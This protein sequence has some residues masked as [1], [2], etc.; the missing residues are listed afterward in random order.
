[1]ASYGVFLAAC[2]FEYH[3][4]KG[5]IGFAPRLTPENFKA[6][7]TSADGWGTFRQ[8]ISDKNHEAEIELRLGTLHVRTL[9]LATAA[10]PRIVTVTVAGD[11]AANEH[12]MENGRL[13]ITLT[14]PAR[15]E[16]GE[17]INIAIS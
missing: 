16:A 11:K 1:M 3:G 17:K 12:R 8:T 4:P 7:F 6:A 9:A 15:I 14:D 2:G 13:L 10:E 5:H